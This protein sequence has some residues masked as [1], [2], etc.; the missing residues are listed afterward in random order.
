MKKYLIML[1]GI[2]SFFNIN[3]VSASSNLNNYYDNYVLYSTLEDNY[4][5]VYGFFLGT[6][7]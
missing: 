4:A 5:E 1:I 2:V 7:M 6:D 3:S